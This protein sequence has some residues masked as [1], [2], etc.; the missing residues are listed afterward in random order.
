QTNRHSYSRQGCAEPLVRTEDG[1]FAQ[2]EVTSSGLNNGPLRGK[3]RY[4][5][6]L[7]C[8]LTSATGAARYDTRFRWHLRQHPYLTQSG[9]DRDRDETQYV[10]NL[11]D[12]AVV[13]FKYFDITQLRE[14]DVEVRGNFAGQVMVGERADFAQL[15]GECQVDLRSRH[16]V[17]KTIATSIPDG[18]H[19]LYLSFRGTGHVDLRAVVLS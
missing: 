6:A 3:G 14:I 10:A 4:P 12:G 16:F 18:V 11:R 5:A 17:T 7:A 1:G 19:G 9:K 8:H 13:G 15:R 2:A